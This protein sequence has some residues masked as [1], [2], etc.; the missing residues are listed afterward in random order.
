MGL[1]GIIN[2][3]Y[4]Y[5]MLKAQQIYARIF[6]T[7]KFSF[8]KVEYAKLPKING[9]LYLKNEGKL[10]LGDHISFNS[11]FYSNPMG[12]NKCCSI[13]VEKNG[14]LTIDNNSGFSGVSIYCANQISIGRNLFCGGNVS[15]WDTDF[16]PL[17]SE[18]RIENRL[19]QIKTK[20]I[21]IGNEVFIGANSIILKGVSIGD[22]SIIGAGSVVTKAVPANEIWAGNPAVFIKN[23]T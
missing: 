15:I 23:I 13:F 22:C 8:N 5:P 17:K 3:M 14:R 18:D 12:L 4:M 16:H 19:D 7:M 6:Y 10:K 2:R 20:P 21:T 9:R 11:T 1:K